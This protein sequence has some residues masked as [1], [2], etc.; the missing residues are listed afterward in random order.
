MAGTTQDPK[1]ESKRVVR[2]DVPVVGHRPSGLIEPAHD[3][4]GAIE[5][6]SRPLLVDAPRRGRV[7]SRVG[8]LWSLAAVATI[9]SAI[10]TKEFG[11]T[12][13]MAML[14]RGTTASATAVATSAPAAGASD[15]E[16]AET[17]WFDGRPVRPARTIMMRVTAYSPHAASCYPYA[18][19]QTA[20]LHSVYTN[21]GMLVAADTD[22]L[23]FGSMLT[24]PGY[25]Q[26]RIVPVL[27]RGGAIKGNRLDVLF[28]THEAALEWGVRDVPVVVW[29]FADGKPAVDPRKLRS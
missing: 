5:P 24:I 3:L 9:A 26:G 14:D 25:D 8:L 4:P 15:Q 6:A 2:V 22:V 21:G 23:P 16:I 1:V 19:G 7:P 12:R 29:E 17:R 28:P 18:D 10:L 27:D 13:P 20:T 11:T